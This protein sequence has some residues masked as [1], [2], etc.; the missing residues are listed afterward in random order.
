MA[1]VEGQA[2]KTSAGWFGWGATETQAGEKKTVAQLRDG[3]GTSIE[4]VG[5]RGQGAVKYSDGGWFRSVISPGTLF[6][7]QVRDGGDS[8][9]LFGKLDNVGEYGEVLDF[10]QSGDSRAVLKKAT[11]VATGT[12]PR[13]VSVAPGSTSIVEKFGAP[14]VAPTTVRFF[15]GDSIQVQIY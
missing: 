1:T 13:T 10:S 15:L 4:E 5:F 11:Y 6:R 14:E 9:V 3:G 12:Q 8:S 2:G 7:A